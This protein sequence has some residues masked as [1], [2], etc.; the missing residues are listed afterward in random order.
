MEIN[1]LTKSYCSVFSCSPMDVCRTI[2]R[3]RIIEGKG[4]WW[5]DKNMVDLYMKEKYG[6][7]IHVYTGASK[8]IDKRVWVAYAIP[9]LLV[10]AKRISDDLAVYTAELISIWVALL[11]VE[12]YRPKGTVIGTDASSALVSLKNIQL[13]NWQDVVLN[14]VQMVN[15]LHKSQLSITFV[16]VPAHIGVKGHELADTY[17]T[18]V[19]MLIIVKLN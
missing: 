3:P 2:S 9:E 16:W 14:I 7:S 5:W 4:K 18:Y 11:W 19:L 10:T 8:I 1:T 6:D 12:E 17:L 13:E 15:N